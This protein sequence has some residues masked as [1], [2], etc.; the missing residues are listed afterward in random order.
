MPEKRPHPENSLENGDAKRSRSNNGSPVPASTN[1]VTGGASLTE[2]ERRKAQAAER[3]AAIKAKMAGLA[4]AKAPPAPPTT[5]SSTSSIKEDA[6]AK[7]AAMKARLS[8]AAPSSPSPSPAP[9]SPAPATPP[10]TAMADGGRQS[11]LQ[12][13][14]AAL[15]AKAAQSQPQRQN[16]PPAVPQREDNTTRARGGLGIG[17]HPALM[18]DPTKSAARDQQ[19]QASKNKKPAIANPYLDLSAP[20]GEELGDDS[21]F[22]TRIGKARTDRKSRAIVFNQKGKF[23]AQA[24][25]LRAQERLEKMKQEMQAQARKKAIEEATERSYLVQAP[26]DIEWWDEGLVNGPSYDAINTPGGI[27]FD[28]VTEYVQ[29]PIL[30][31]PPQDKLM[32][33]AKPMYLTKKEQAKLRRQRR[34]E[35]HKEEQAKI[36]LGLVPPPPPKVKKTNLMRVLGQEAVNDPTAVEARVNREIAE[37][38]DKHE[39][40]NEARKLTKEQRHEKLTAQQDAD[41]AKGLRVA[42]FRV[43][44]LSNG[45]HRFKVDINAKQNK[46][47][48]IIVLHPRMNL[49]IVEG[50]AHSVNA[51]KKLMLNRIKWDENVASLGDR[52]QQSKEE[53]GKDWLQ[54]LDDEGRLKDLSD[55]RCTLVWEGDEKGRA[56]RKWGSRVCETDGEAKDALARM[57]MENMWT[58]AQSMRLDE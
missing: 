33:V 16:A 7:I 18:G 9:R 4:Q 5:T 14:I 21:A 41:A 50:G 17:L 40:Q 13:Q 12:A 38:A 54:P 35:D 31:E 30:L 34:M 11:Q 43:E 51:Y 2:E 39:E 27:K 23:I 48:G 28:V 19:G 3:L 56:F 32:H 6:L 49:V 55:N 58:L 1:G 57:R 29:H 46:L 47:T 10:P 36:R 42:V 8:G 45:Q 24:E 37:R 25:A 53:E 26:P 44:N 52:Q 15:R 20:A 22:D